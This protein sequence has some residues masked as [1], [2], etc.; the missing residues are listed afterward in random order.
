MVLSMLGIVGV[1]DVTGFGTAFN[2]SSGGGSL[3]T[4]NVSTHSTA[5]Q[6]ANRL[7]FI[8]MTKAMYLAG[9]VRAAIRSEYRS[10]SDVEKIKAQIINSIDYMIEK[11]GDE[12]ASDPYKNY[13]I[14]VDNRNIYSDIENLRS[15]FAKAIKQKFIN[16]P[17]EVEEEISPEGTTILHLAY[18]KYL[19]IS[20]DE[21]V[22]K[23]NQP[24]LKHPGFVLDNVRMLSE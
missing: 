4:I 10:L 3:T 18:G 22:F 8:N 15:E 7:A 6:A 21:E 5:R 16:L 12:S 20:R 13:G 11:L 1:N 14:Y 17:Y 19:D 23:R 24:T 9:S 2:A